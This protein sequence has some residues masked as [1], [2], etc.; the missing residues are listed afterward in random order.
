MGEDQGRRLGGVDAGEADVSFVNPFSGLASEAT[1]KDLLAELLQKLEAGQQVALTPATVADLKSNAT[2]TVSNPGASEA[3]V[4]SVRDNVAA[5]VARGL[6]TEATL[7]AVLARLG[8]VFGAV[9]GLE[10]S[11]GNIDISNTNI[12]L[13]VDELEGLMRAVRDRLPA[14]GAASEAT[15]AGLAAE[16]FASQT[17]LAAVRAR[18]D[19]LASEATLAGLAAEDFATQA[20]LASLLA[21]VRRRPVWRTVTAV[22]LGVASG[23]WTTALTVG[24]VAGALT[25]VGYNADLRSLG[26]ARYG[27]RFTLNGVGDA[28]VLHDE[29]LSTGDNSWAPVRW[30]VA[31]GSTL[32]VQVI[33]GELGAQD[34]RATMNY[35]EEPA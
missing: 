29:Q 4:L 16:D 21:E 22:A 23:A 19:L 12:G 6:S 10:I 35:F 9:D 2:V 25:V 32:R 28:A 13:S 8:D 33:H 30:T 11:A 20:T 3:S 26:N 17:T 24:P 18:A 14:L 31:A 15:L 5:L 27:M 7:L 34:V 1:L